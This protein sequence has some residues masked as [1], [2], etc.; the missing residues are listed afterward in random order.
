LLR[1]AT[2]AIEELSKCG[3]DLFLAGHL[4][5]GHIGNTINR[6]KL[7]ESEREYAALIVSAG[8]ATSSRTRG[9]EPNSFNVIDVE[10]SAPD[11]KASAKV[12]RYAWDAEKQTYVSILNEHYVHAESGDKKFV[13][14]HQPGHQ[15]GATESSTVDV[16]SSEQDKGAK[17]A[18]DA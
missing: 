11:R 16:P 14:W 13:G 6:Y 15:E 3:A 12:Q 10:P 17:I 8:T 18:E 4:H 2:A 9:G 5:L 1:H 7:K